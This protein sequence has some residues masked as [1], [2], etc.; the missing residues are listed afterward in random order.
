MIH[1]IVIYGSPVLETE[2]TLVTDFG[3]ALD[4]L[5]EDMFETMRDAE[6]VGLA[7]PQI[8]LGMRLAV[9]DLGW[10]KGESEPL[11]L[12][13]PEIIAREG[14]QNGPEGCLSLPGLRE[15]TRRAS[16]VTVRAQ[17]R[18]GAWYERTGEGLLARAFEHEVDHLHKTLFFMRLGPLARKMVVSK[19]DKLRRAGKWK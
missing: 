13:N 1:P 8:G 9:I 12:A 19:V 10:E 2:T 16:K 18:T 5:V 14:E 15:P 6:G 3:E 7:A 17:D 4:G 11:V